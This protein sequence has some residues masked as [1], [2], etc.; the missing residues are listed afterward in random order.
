M[1][2]KEIYDAVV[3][4]MQPA[5]ELGGPEGN[6]YISLMASIAAEASSRAQRYAEGWPGAEPMR[7]LSQDELL[8]AQ[9]FLDRADIVVARHY[10]MALRKERDGTGWCVLHAPLNGAD[11]WFDDWGPIE[12]GPGSATS[13]YR[14][15]AAADWLIQRLGAPPPPPASSSEAFMWGIVEHAHTIDQLEQARAALVA[16][17][18]A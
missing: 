18:D 10:G 17:G 15:E 7:M 14:T 2:K 6:E 12:R 13:N 11:G 9:G 5:E 3:A 8:A 4:A 16:R 1:T